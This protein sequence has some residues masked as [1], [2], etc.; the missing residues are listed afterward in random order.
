LKKIA[1][2]TQS[3]P[4]GS[5]QDYVTRMPFSKLLSSSRGLSLTI[6]KK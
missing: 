2:G 4:T 6:K 3:S 1:N 5:R